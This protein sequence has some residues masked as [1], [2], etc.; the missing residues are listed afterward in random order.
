MRERCVRFTCRALGS[1]YPRHSRKFILLACGRVGGTTLLRLLNAHPSVRYV[2][3]PLQRKVRH[4]KA[5]LEEYALRH[6]LRGNVWG[7][8][9]KYWH[10]TKV[11]GLD[12]AI[13][14]LQR[15][16][17]DGWLVVH[18]KRENVVKQTIAGLV[19]I[20]GG[21]VHYH[22]DP[23]IR[24]ELP[25]KE[26]GPSVSSRASAAEEEAEIA[27]AIPTLRLTYERDILDPHRRQVACDRIFANLGLDSCSVAH[28]P[29]KTESDNLHTYVLNATEV[30]R[31][32]S[33]QGL[34]YPDEASLT[35]ASVTNVI[36]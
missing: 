32:L 30:E 20:H 25:V 17:S 7:C 1:A 6:A 8:K 27:K 23:S 2:D 26:I 15:A 18:L 10:L 21:G 34:C 11:Q 28:V 36:E 19:R 31:Y 5:L 29:V 16:V 9:I 35:E 3:E 14:F 22:T 12:S 24:V 4:P 33:E 13:P